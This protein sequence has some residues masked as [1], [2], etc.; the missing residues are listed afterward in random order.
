MS[1]PVSIIVNADDLGISAEVNDAI[2][3]L[4]AQGKVTSATILANGPAVE[5]ACRQIRH[6]PQCSFG[7]HL[8]LTQFRPLSPGA[9]LLLDPE[10]QQMTRAIANA[11]P[12]GALRQVVYD[13]FRAQVERVASL[14]VA[15]SHLDSHHHI[16]TRPF[17]FLP[18]KAV[19]RQFQIR[20]VRLSKNLY[21]A[22]DQPPTAMLWTKRIYNAALRRH[23]RTSTTAAFTELASYA[24]LVRGAIPA[25]ASVELMTH[26]GAAKYAEETALLEAGWNGA[27]Q[28][29]RLISYAALPAASSS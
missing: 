19:Q 13:E 26:P 14:G 21:C 20:R 23:Y 28:G 6:F 12:S 5:Q 8:N 9:S 29:F 24:R 7:V 2:F 1:E 10:Q 11:R 25:F 4:M 16:H 27:W 3:R 22:E 18:L 17:A 15:V